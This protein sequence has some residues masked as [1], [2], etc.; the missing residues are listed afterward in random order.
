MIR[1][2]PLRVL[3]FDRVLEAISGY[4]RCEAS[5]RAVL[6]ILPLRSRKRI[7]ER[8]A[9]VAEARRLSAEGSPLPVG[10]FHD[11]SD[12][13]RRV[14]PEGAVLEP[15]E[16]HSF[17]PLLQTVMDV[18]GVLEGRRDELPA[19]SGIVKGL[20]AQPDLLASIERSLDGDG[21]ILDTASYTLSDLRADIRRLNARIKKRLEE[22]MRSRELGKF[23]QDEFVTQRSGRWVI[24][25]RMD[26]KGQVP[27]VVHDVSR[28]GE[29][30]FVEPLEI[31][32]LANELENLVA[33]EKAEEIRVLRELSRWV[34]GLAA[35][36]EAQ[37]RA[38]VQLDVLL[39]IAQFSDR[40]RMEIPEIND[41][42]ELRI[43]GGRHPL[44][45]VMRGKE[46]VPLDLAI[47]GSAGTVMV[48][49]GPNAGGKTIAIK[50]AGLLSAMALSGMPVPARP[51]SSFPLAS[52]I[53]VDIGDE[54]SIEQSLST[55][56]AHIANLSG[57][58][59]KAGP[60]AL[61]LLDELGTGTDP[62]EG[63]A[64]GCAVLKEL[65][66]RQAMVL[67]T[68][69]L[70]D[71]VG[72]VH[73]TEGMVNASMEFDSETLTPLYRLRAGEPGQSH[74]IDI[75]GRF[76]LPESTLSLARGMLGT[77]EAELQ[78]LLSDLRR[79]RAEYEEALGGLKKRE[80]EAAERER[81]LKER[82]SSVEAERGKALEE[83]LRE[84]RDIV[85]GAKREAADALKEVRRAK[86]RAAL[87]GLEERRREVEAR[88]RELRPEPVLALDDINEGDTVHVRSFGM[89]AEVTGVD[90][91]RGRLKVTAGNMTIEVP[92]SDVGPPGGVGAARG[93]SP[94]RGREDEEKEVPAELNLIGLRVEEAVSRLEAFLNDS[95]LAG[96][97][98]VR[99]I[100]GL[101]TGALQRA[102]REHLSGHPLVA[103][104]ERASQREGGAGATLARLK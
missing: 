95:F 92:A 74:G 10:R 55:F 89:D 46:V 17:A 64:I 28:T 54:Q 18:L 94:G 41:G 5:R 49:T 87:K 14:R 44:L 13:L 11:V 99:I 84:A 53:F 69:H 22:I 9:A 57:I 66:E 40:L 68:T 2:E 16:L 56:S 26:A 63:A 93:P 97:R 86:S 72:F 37:F 34:R 38:A 61:V 42:A 58:L 101:G 81:A 6:D 51:S 78:G 33:E 96:A 12:A 4:A 71:V 31:I 77:L 8:F 25:V 60:R 48:I 67:A 15:L 90:R 32:G 80:A 29:T 36:L 43:E 104:F 21:N 102:V 27:G 65:S 1:K 79:K 82:L 52:D 24:P 70:T 83:A 59:A 45:L 62:R 3:E 75:A 47:G 30:A 98:E 76:G 85:L 23:L 73:R 39:C 103:G 20:E 50:T 7:T 88:L 100:H 35:E 19:L 91:R